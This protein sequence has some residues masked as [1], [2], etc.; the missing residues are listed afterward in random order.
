MKKLDCSSV[1]SILKVES[2]ER[3]DEEISIVY[4]PSTTSKSFV[5]KV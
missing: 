4:F 3:P 5:I 2:E 1:L